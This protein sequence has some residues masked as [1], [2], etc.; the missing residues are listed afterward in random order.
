MTD[1]PLHVRIAT[2]ERHVA[3]LEGDRINV[4]EVERLALAPTDVL[5]VH[6][7][8]DTSPEE[9]HETARI[10]AE[11]LG[12]RRVLVLAGETRVSAA[13]LPPDPP[14]AIATCPLCGGAGCAD[15]KGTGVTDA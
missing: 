7:A 15:C 11:H 13:E 5:C 2:L 3:A 12:T 4:I 10:I 8:D 6:V 14:P 9:M 1:L